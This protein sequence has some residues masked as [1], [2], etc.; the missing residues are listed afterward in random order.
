MEEGLI[1]Q[2]IDAEDH[3]CICME[4]EKYA[5]P[6]ML[7]KDLLLQN[8]INWQNTGRNVNAQIA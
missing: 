6:L 3:L 5:N 1:Q 7:P 8:V 2:K 4:I